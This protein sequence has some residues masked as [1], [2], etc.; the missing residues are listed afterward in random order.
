M[1]KLTEH[2]V[3]ILSACDERGMRLPF[4][5]YAAS[6]NGSV[7][8]IR[9]DDDAEPDVLADHFEPEGFKV[10]ITCMVLDQTGE[11]VRITI[12]ASRLTFH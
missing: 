5:L 12:D 4:I 7:L 9:L 3:E 11:A 10:P 2:L 6:P 1:N 8:C